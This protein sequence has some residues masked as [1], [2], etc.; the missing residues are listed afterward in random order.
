MFDKGYG[1]L[2]AAIASSTG[3]L[4]AIAFFLVWAGLWLPLAIPV[5][6]VLKWRPLSPMK[7][8]QKLPLLA[9][10]YLIAPLIVWGASWAE[11]SSFSD[12]GLEWKLSTLVS[13]S[14]GLG[15]GVLSLAVIFGLE[16]MLGWIEWQKEEEQPRDWLSISKSILLPTLLIGLLVSGIEELI[17]RGFLLNELQQDYSVLVAAAISSVIFALLHLVWEQQETL[18]QLPGLWLMGMV[19]VLARIVDG[20]S[21]G[22]AWGLHAGWIW[23]IA[24][25][26]TARLINYT[27]FVPA[28]M[29][30]IREK[31]LAGG[32]G[33]V[34]L[35]GTAAVLWSF[36]GYW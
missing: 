8:E 19:L 31:P 22:L 32:A 15:L 4:K 5:A 33:I 3:L 1:Q 11:G 25:L 34:C 6:I 24:S 7:V 16:G 30:G 14:L 28:W 10:L 23:G 35:L 13:L 29:T 27:S 12:Y 17:F 20:G 26:D 9:S 36:S 18:P 21:L 2:Q